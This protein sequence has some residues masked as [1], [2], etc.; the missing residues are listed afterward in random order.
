MHAIQESHSRL[1]EYAVAIDSDRAAFKIHYWGAV[2]KLP[3]NPVHRHSF[4]EICYVMGGEGEYMDDGNLYPLAP[5]DHFCS[6]PGVTHQIR[7]D[8]G[9]FLLYVAFELDL[10]RTVPE[11]ISQFDEMSVHGVPWVREPVPGPTALLWQSLLLHDSPGGALQEPSLQL[12]ICALLHSFPALFGPASSNRAA[13]RRASSLLRQ[14]KLFIGDNIASPLTLSAVAGYLN[15]SERHLS[16][17][18]NDGIKESFTQYVRA[19]RVRQA[20]KW[21]A[22]SE[23]PIKEIAEKVGFGS[24]HYFTRSFAREKQMP[25]GQYRS[26]YR[27]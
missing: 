27:E 9:L 11:A 2:A 26:R 4:F 20:A 1:N 13:G 10:S 3:T 23:L 19:E 16:R 21:L 25:P 15:V 24:V 22:T 5:G 6:R 17:L 14:A 8:E 12:A 7:T 18:F